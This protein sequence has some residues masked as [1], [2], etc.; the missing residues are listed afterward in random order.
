MAY[1]DEIE[2]AVLRVMRSN[3][4]ILGPEVA[5]LEQEFSEFIGAKYSIG[6]ANG[7]DAIELALRALNIGPGDEVITVSHTAV[8]T[9]SAIEASG[10]SPVLVDVDQES[11]LLNTN[12]LQEVLTI[13]TKA[14]IAVHLYGH[15]ANLDEIS[16]FCK[17]NNLFLIEDCSQAHGAK[18]RGERVGKVGVIG[19][20]SCYPT[21]NLGAIGDAGIVTTDDAVLADKIKMLREYGWS[22]RYISDLSGRNS[23]LDEIQAAIL[24]V[25]LKH[26]ESDNRKRRRL[27]DLYTDGL[28]GMALKLPLIH[29][30]ADPVFH[31]YVVRLAYRNQLLNYLNDNNVYPGIHYPVPIHLQPA[32]KNSIRTARSMCVTEALADEILSLPLYPELKEAEVKNVVG[33]IS[34]FMRKNKNE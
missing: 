28:K 31:L 32:Y 11:Y 34:E 22:N 9:V 2:A 29:E 4:Y 23:R 13:K 19:C 7:T 5:A 16:I 15:P 20:F 6:V 30:K 3:R 18:W 12:Q 24:R 14:V 27:A 26:L 21:K 25:K 1:Q 17:K 33:L 10:A 8:A